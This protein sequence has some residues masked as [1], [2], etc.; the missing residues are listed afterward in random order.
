MCG[1][2]LPENDDN[3]YHRP[4]GKNGLYASCIPCIKAQRKARWC[5]EAETSNLRR[6]Q[7]YNADRARNVTPGFVYTIISDPDPIG[8]FRRGAM[9]PKMQ[10]DIGLGMG[11]FNNG[12]IIRVRTKLYSVYG[13]RL[14]ETKGG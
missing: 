10:F 2:S 14:I 8:G 13:T 6:R 3:F 1:V 5:R 4:G 11:V 12:M 9:I 7:N